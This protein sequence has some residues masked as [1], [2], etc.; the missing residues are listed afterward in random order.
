MKQNPLDIRTVDINKIKPRDLNSN[1]MR[2]SK[3]DF[4][5]K[6]MGKVG[7]VQPIIVYDNGD[8]TYTIIDGEHRL[9]AAKDN[10]L[11]ELEV[12]VTTLTPQ[13]QDIMSVN[14][15]LIHGEINPSVFAELLGRIVDA[16]DPL[17]PDKLAELIALE[18][19]EAEVWLHISKEVEDIEDTTIIQDEKNKFDKIVYKFKVNEEDAEVVNDCIRRAMQKFNLEEVDD[20]LF[21]ISAYFL[22]REELDL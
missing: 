21:E 11:S 4:L 22:A 5:V 1:E 19:K 2:Q 18:K 14:M 20:V 3:Y 6:Y 16:N 9:R 8:D 15:N 12:I 13:E 7:Y 10:K 17:A